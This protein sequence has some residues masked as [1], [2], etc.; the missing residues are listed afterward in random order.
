MTDEPGTRAVDILI[1]D[2]C[3]ISDDMEGLIDVMKSAPDG[4]AQ[5]IESLTEQVADVKTRI[6]RSISEFRMRAQPPCLT[7]LGMDEMQTAPQQNHLPGNR[8]C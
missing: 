2:L 7:S 5:V 3:E 4:L 1:E 6:D 8:N